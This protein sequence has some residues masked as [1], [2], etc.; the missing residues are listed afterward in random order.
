MQR[1]TPSDKKLGLDRTP[2]STGVPQSEENAVRTGNEGL[3]KSEM[4]KTYTVLGVPLDVNNYNV[5]LP[6]AGIPQPPDIEDIPA[7]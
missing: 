1:V 2:T 7:K 4:R 5:P 6:N 3:P